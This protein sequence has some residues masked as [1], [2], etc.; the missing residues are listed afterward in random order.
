MQSLRPQCDFEKGLLFSMFRFI[1]LLAFSITLIG[2][3][4]LFTDL[5]MRFFDSESGVVSTDMKLLFFPFL[6]K[7]LLF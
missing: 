5:C 2:I 7:Q 1:E 4:S 6:L 3:L